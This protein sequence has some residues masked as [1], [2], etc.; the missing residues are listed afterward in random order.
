MKGRAIEASAVKVVSRFTKREA[1]SSATGATSPA[2]SASAL[3]KPASRVCGLARFLVTGSRSSSSGS[4]WSIAVFRSR[5]RPANPVPMPSSEFCEPLRALSSNMLKKSSISTTA[6]RAWRIG[7]VAPALKP[8]WPL[9]GSICR[10]LRPRVDRGRTS[11]VESAGS[12]S[13]SLSSFSVI[14]A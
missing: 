5:P 12:G 6:G 4:S 13:I 3:K 10:Y 1:C 9:P 7:I 8:A 11:T 2:V 14:W